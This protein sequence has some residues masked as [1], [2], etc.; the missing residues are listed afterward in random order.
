MLRRIS[1][2]VEQFLSPHQSG[3]RPCR[4]TAD[5][6]WTHRW[7]ASRAQRYKERFH[8]LII[9]LSRAFVTV[10]RG[11]PLSVPKTLLYDDETR[12]IR[13][14]DT[15]I[16]LR[17]VNRLLSPFESNPGIPQGDSLPPVIFVVYLEADPTISSLT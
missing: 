8:I 11:K 5:A 2:K 12:L 17:L 4:S 1:L 3:L 13:L 9:D 7:I 14:R 10:N 6:V 16:F 15:M